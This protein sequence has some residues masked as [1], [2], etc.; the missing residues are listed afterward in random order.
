MDVRR[1]R[2]FGVLIQIV[3]FHQSNTGGVVYAPH[4]RGVV[5]RWQVCDDRRFPCRRAERSRCLRISRTWSLVIIP[6]IIVVLQ[7]SLE[8]I[9]APVPSCSSKVGLA[10]ALG[11]LY[12]GAPSSGPMARTITLFGCSPLN[13]EPANHHVVARLHKAASAN[14]A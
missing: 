11:I 9:K 2:R 12:G 10:N 6:P 13:N 4:D 1:D 3:H 14:V 5:T 7:L 8:A